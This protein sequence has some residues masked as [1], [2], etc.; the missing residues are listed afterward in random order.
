MPC[1]YPKVLVLW[2]QE[3]MICVK[4]NGALYECFS[5]SNGIKLGHPFPQIVQYLC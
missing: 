1:L 2:Y 5:V 3:Q 4:W